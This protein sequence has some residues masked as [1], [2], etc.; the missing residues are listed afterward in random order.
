MD[1]E[2]V[3]INYFDCKLNTFSDDG[4]CFYFENNNK[5]PFC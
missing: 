2:M 3:E 1:Y 5:I 4:L